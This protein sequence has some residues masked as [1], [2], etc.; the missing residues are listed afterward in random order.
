MLLEWI[1]RQKRKEAVDEKMAHDLINIRHGLELRKFAAE[2]K[3]EADRLRDERNT[4]DI[5]YDIGT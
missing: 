3:K 2:L 1:L 5:L 4:I